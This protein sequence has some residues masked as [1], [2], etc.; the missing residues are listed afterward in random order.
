MTSQTGFDLLLFW[1][2]PDREKAAA[3]YEMV[4]R[5][6]IEIF[7]SRGF[8]NADSLADTTID[9]VISKVP[10][11]ADGWVGDPLIFFLA[12][13]KKI[14][15]EN[16]KPPRTILPP[17]PPPDPDKLEREDRCIEKG[18]QLLSLEDRELVLEY[19]DGNKKTRQEIANRLGITLNALRLR[20]YQ[21]KKTIRP[22]IKECLEHEGL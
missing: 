2:N 22:T 17:P 11:V 5:R 20:I 21:I 10:Q 9:R 15:L 16:S 7:A 12:V 8:A 1:L 19:V 13:A 4:R 6:L 3:K 14:I 18:L